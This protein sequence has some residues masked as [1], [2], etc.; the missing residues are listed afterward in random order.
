MLE[1]TVGRG[2]FSRFFDASEPDWLIGGGMA[3]TRRFG[4]IVIYILRMHIYLA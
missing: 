2:G 4:I 3:V 1:E